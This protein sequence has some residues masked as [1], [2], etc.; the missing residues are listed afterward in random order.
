[1]LVDDPR[2]TPMR[3]ALACLALLACATPV[4][5]DTMHV[6]DPGAEQVVRRL[7]DLVTFPA[8]TTP[9]WDEVRALF[10]DEAVVVLRTGREE[11]SVFTL[12]G[13]I[14]DFVSFIETANVR[15]T[16][17][18]ER[19]LALEAMTYGDMAHVLVRFDSHIPGSG[20]PP[21]EGLDS[22]ELVRRDGRWLVV[23][24][25]NERPTAERP[26]PDALFAGG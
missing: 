22:F 17:F 4:Q 3:A 20:R 8:G 21:G 2:E 23:A 1:M 13:F 15:E 19:V 5:E 25:V 14:A 24:I 10:V 12:D 9:D 26:I 7:Y 18:T 11:M 16:G 6:I